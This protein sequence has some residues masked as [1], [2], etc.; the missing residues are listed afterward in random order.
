MKRKD[1]FTSSGTLKE[2]SPFNKKISVWSQSSDC[3]GQRFHRSIRGI[4]QTK[5]LEPSC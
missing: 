1:A 4:E 2:Q 5:Y 3:F